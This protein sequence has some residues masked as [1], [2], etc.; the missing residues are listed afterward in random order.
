MPSDK[1]LQKRASLSA[2]ANEIDEIAGAVQLYDARDGGLAQQLAVA[3]A[4]VDM[5]SLLTDEVMQPVMALMNTGL[6]FVTDQDPNRPSRNNP[7]PKPYSVAVVREVVIEAKLRGFNLVGQEFNII[8]SKFYA[9]KNGLQRKLRDGKTIKGLAKF[10]DF[11]E[12]PKLSS[13][14]QSAVVKCH[15]TWEMNGKPER[16][17]FEFFVKLHGMGPDAALGKA[18]RRLAKEVL[19]F[20]TG[21]SVPD[22][23]VDDDAVA[24]AKPANAEETAPKRGP[25]IRRDPVPTD[26]QIPGAEM[27][28][29]AAAEPANGI[30]ANEGQQTGGETA[31]STPEGEGNGAAEPQA[32]AQQAPTAPPPPP[33]QPDPAPAQP[34]G[35]VVSSTPAPAAAP[36]PAATA[37]RVS[38]E[39]SIRNQGIA[40]VDAMAQI[41]KSF[42]EATKN[43]RTLADVEEQLPNV[44]NAIRRSWSGFTSLC[45]EQKAARE[46][47]EASAAEGGEAPASNE[48]KLL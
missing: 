3:Q 5:R 34:I 48:G 47:A 27:P 19:K 40:P 39:Q 9:A 43:C 31:P 33:P 18:E 4:V 42:P 2:V 28:P 17:D 24:A 14:G 44:V 6:G 30:P 38:F 10:R 25:R 7:S 46:R 15:A 13:D 23:D 8:A 16:V 1:T 45:A 35:K 41:R 22:G 20:V 11:Y 32:T 26:D 29:A 21:E 36:K 12:L 37:G